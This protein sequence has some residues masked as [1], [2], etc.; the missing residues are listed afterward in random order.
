MEFKDMRDSLNLKR[1]QTILLETR[2]NDAEHK[3]AGR[4]N[5]SNEISSQAT[6]E[7]AD[8]RHKS[9]KHV[10]LRLVIVVVMFH[11]WQE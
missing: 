2:L 4:S 6:I 10:S 7:Q 3:L 1:D 8:A 5:R 9:V 11:F